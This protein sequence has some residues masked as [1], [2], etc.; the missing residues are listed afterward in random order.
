[1]SAIDDGPRFPDTP[2]DLETRLAAL[3]APPA[4]SAEAARRRVAETL[5]AVH[6]ALVANRHDTAALESAADRAADVLAALQSPV[7]AA[8]HG[9]YVNHSPIVGRAN[10]VAPP[11]EMWLEGDRVVGRAVLGDAYEGPPDHVH[12]GFVA[13]MLDEILGYVQSLGGNP[14]MTGR[15]NVAYRA[16]TPLHRELRL[17]G[18]VERVDG[19]KTHTHATIHDG[20]RL[21]A[22]AEGLFVA[23]GRE[24]FEAMAADKAK[25]R[26]EG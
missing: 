6:Q 26:A 24:A 12:G 15:L 18:R 5:R 3:A 7:S 16:P 10:P 4:D 11:V 13:A 2:F 19:R 14:G 25:R 8:D 22:E 9:D 20:D 21:C 1:M 23:I 17:E